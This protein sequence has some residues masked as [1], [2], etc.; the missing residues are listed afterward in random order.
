MKNLTLK[1]HIFQTQE[2]INAND[3]CQLNSNISLITFS[4]QNKKILLISEKITE[5]IDELHRIYTVVVINLNKNLLGLIF[6]NVKKSC[7]K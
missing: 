6:L 2:V 5:K 7:D 1:I 3:Y 4:L